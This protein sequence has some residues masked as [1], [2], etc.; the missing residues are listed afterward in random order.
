MVGV[1]AEEK[2]RGHWN[3]TFYCSIGMETH[4]HS[5]FIAR[6]LSPGI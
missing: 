2:R 4:V 1:Y 6:I 3:H 5:S